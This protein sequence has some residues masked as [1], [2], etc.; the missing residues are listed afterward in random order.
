VKKEEIMKSTH[1]HQEAACPQ[2]IF[3]DEALTEPIREGDESGWTLWGDISTRVIPVGPRH[4]WTPVALM[5]NRSLSKIFGP[6]AA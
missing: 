1:H 5:G 6:T 3:R 2:D 4:I